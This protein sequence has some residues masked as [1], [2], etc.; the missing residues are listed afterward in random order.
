MEGFSVEN[1]LRAVHSMYGNTPANYKEID[2]W[3]KT[4]QKSSDSWGITDNIFSSVGLPEYVYIF[5]AQTLKT[6]LMYDFEELKGMDLGPFKSN[7]LS[8]GLKFAS[9]EKVMRQLAQSIGILAIHLVD[10]WGENMLTE[11]SN[12]FS[13]NTLLLLETLKSIAEEIN[14]QTIV[15]DVDKAN[16][17]KLILESQ[18]S[19]II[20]YLENCSSEFYATIL[21]VFLVWVQ[22]GIDAEV[23]AILPRSRL[24]QLSFDAL[25]M[26]GQ[27]DTAC[28]VICELISLTDDYS[29]YGETVQVLV[30][31]LIGLKEETRKVLEDE[32]IIDG[33]IKLYTTLGNAHLNMM[34]QEQSRDMLEFL[35]ELFS[36]RTGEGIYQL[37]Q[38]WHRFC[39]VIKRK[40]EDERQRYQELTSYLMQKLLPIC[41][42]QY[43]LSVDEL[44]TSIEKETEEIRYNVSVVLQDIV[45]FLSEDTV[46]HLFSN[47]LSQILS[48]DSPNTYE[49]F[50][51]IEAIAGCVISMSELCKNSSLSN[52]YLQLS[53]EVWPVAQVNTTVCKIFSSI[54][55]PLPPTSLPPIIT[56]LVNCLKAQVSSKVVA[57]A[58]KNICI[59][60][61]RDLQND[62]A[63]LLHLHT[64][65]QELSSDAQELILEGIAA[66]IW[67]TPLAD[68][69]IFNLC[70]VYTKALATD[71]SEEA[72][73]ANC[74][75]IAVIFK[76][77]SDKEVDIMSVY[78]LFKEMWPGLKELVG[79]YQN[80]DSAVEALCRIVKH[81]MK[82]LQLAFG[83]FLGDFMQI[84]SQQFLQYKHSSYL[85]MAEQLVKIFG[86]SN[87]YE[88]MLIELFNTLG[89]AALAELNSPQSLANNPELTEDFFGMTTRYLHYCTERALRS[90]NFE[91]ILV[92]AKASIG[93]QHLEAA[94]CLYGYLE[95]TFDYCNRDSHS[96]VQYAVE[97]LLPHYRDVLVNLVAAVVSVVPGS[98][99]EFIEE[100]C[101]KILTIEEG[102]EWLTLALANVPHDCLTET[103]KVKFIQQSRQA[104]DI[105]NWLE[106]LYKRSKQRARRLD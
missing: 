50:S 58:V 103:E 44:S 41:L 79:K 14:N 24:L 33:Y 67:R 105:H 26:P 78:A 8:L 66:V 28:G 52:I 68:R 51:Q 36:V 84:I 63:S 102:A 92:L 53:R 16:K 80:N 6:K 35:A 90:Q 76:N 104:R 5:N 82:K 18:A 70:A 38:F 60:N 94:K 10:S 77:G 48:Q 86:S 74:D 101:F 4:Y 95:C 22:F 23:A 43:Q 37:S 89:S 64:I 81:A 55:I 34:I 11:I 59:V 85:Y 13:G 100:I 72:L 20:R 12:A 93:L 73:L 47:Y 32:E 40:P 30:K 71:T 75:K 98:I 1:V 65:S 91:N 25:K 97:R 45:E 57:A 62:F 96:C 3:L 49:K 15:V 21:E 39:R 54:I 46:L 106:R 31:F 27:F 88:D 69:A 17:L 56:Y 99:F 2:N 29:K 9:Q 19:Q 83:E 61:T 7:V 87:L 42:K